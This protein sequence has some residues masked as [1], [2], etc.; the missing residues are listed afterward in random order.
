MPYT[1][2]H[3]G[4]T[5]PVYKRFHRYFSVTGLVFGSIV[6][7]FD[8]L[9]RL[10]N[11]RYHIF[12]Y[13]LK[14]ILFIICPI[15]LICALFFHL[16]CRNVIIEQLPDNLHQKYKR[17]LTV[18]FIKIFKRDYIRIAA[19]VI[20]AILLHIFLDYISHIVDAHSVNCFYMVLSAAPQ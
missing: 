9:F 7:D 3:I 13:D 18:D 6:P 1:F 12:E 11:V 8:I 19:S 14:T 10:T 16:F 4:F 5:L 2:A 17:Y 15:G 20:L